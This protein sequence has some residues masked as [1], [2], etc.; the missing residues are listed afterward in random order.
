MLDSFLFVLMVAAPV[1]I[2]FLVFMYCLEK[3]GKMI[4]DF[5]Q[6]STPEH[7]PSPEFLATC[8]RPEEYL[9]QGSG[10]QGGHP[11]PHTQA[12]A[13]ERIATLASKRPPLSPT[14]IDQAEYEQFMSEHTWTAAD[15]E[16]QKQFLAQA[17][18]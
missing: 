2:G 11:R 1:G 15:D 4:R 16:R 5:P 8:Q 14:T 13:Q 18:R 10:N 12:E 17:D 3:T 6:I 7:S 9:K